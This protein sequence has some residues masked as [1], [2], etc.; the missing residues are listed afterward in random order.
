MGN[1]VAATCLAIQAGF[2]LVNLL[3]GGSMGIALDWRLWYLL[4]PLAKIAAMAP[5]SLGGIGV[6]EAAFAALAGRF[7]AEDRIVAQSLVWESILVVGGLIAG[8]LHL[9]TTPRRGEDPRP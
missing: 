4:W 5:V 9:L 8:G 7:V 2:V 6:R 3:L 1:H